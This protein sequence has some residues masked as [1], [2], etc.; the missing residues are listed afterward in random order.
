MIKATEKA[1]FGSHR[2]NFILVS[3]PESAAAYTLQH[4]PNIL[5]VSIQY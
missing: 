5:N 4:Q 2:V 3:E 1:G